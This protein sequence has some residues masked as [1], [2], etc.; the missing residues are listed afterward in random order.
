MDGFLG[1]IR[2]MAFGFAPSGWVMCNGQLLPIN[3]NQALFALF[4]TTYGGDG[5]TTF[6]LPDLRGRAP[7]CIGGPWALGA[8]FGEEQHQLAPAEMP[9]HQHVLQASSADASQSAPQGALLAGVAGGYAPPGSPTNLDP[10]SVAGAGGS[11]LH[12]NRHP[13]TV[14]SWCVAIQGSTPVPS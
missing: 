1:E 9:A 4:G 6:A 12:E 3:Q 14:L 10:S 11:Q 13:Y 8:S 2:L 5:Q 7:I